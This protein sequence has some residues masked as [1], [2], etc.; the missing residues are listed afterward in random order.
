MSQVAVA[1]RA[2]PE[3]AAPK[4]SRF[5]PPR[6]LRVTREG[7]F[8]VLFTLGVGGAAVNTGNNMLYLL[9]GLQLACIVI[10][11][12][13]SEWALQGLSLRTE[14]AP[15]ARVGEAASWHLVL[16][17]RPGRIPSYTLVLTAMEGP[18]RGAVAGVLR[19]APG[20]SERVALRYTP[21]RRGRFTGRAM[22]VSTRFPF[23]LFEKSRDLEVEGPPQTFFVYPRRR[24][25]PM[26]QGAPEQREG[27]TTRSEPGQGAELLHLREWRPEDGLRNVH[28]RKS[29][30]A[31]RWVAS[32]REREQER[33]IEVEVDLGAQ[34]ESESLEALELRLE[35]AS[36][37]VE[38]ALD[39]QRSVALRLGRQR[40]VDRGDSGGRRRLLRA[41]AEAAPEFGGAP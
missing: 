6:R 17:K 5:R 15:D 19:V 26:P 33:E 38:A 1:G 39:A 31:G 37:E 14:E 30:Q 28:W 22:Q 20:D 40:L 35:R 27:T 2:I 3:E 41:L 36:G 7:W 8:Y 21:T 23:G 11:G 13:L 32:V 24:P 4:R 16:G 29:A 10:S 34:E 9:L 25:M 12:V 18:A